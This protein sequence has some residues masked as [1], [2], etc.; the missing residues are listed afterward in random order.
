MGDISVINK[1][2]CLL[3]FHKYFDEQGKL[4]ITFENSNDG[5]G[6]VKQIVYCRHCGKETVLGYCYNG[7]TNYW[8]EI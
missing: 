1:L 8:M 3:G 2:L 4:K 5:T 6:N 7:N